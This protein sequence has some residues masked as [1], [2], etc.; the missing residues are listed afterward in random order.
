[1]SPVYICVLLPFLCFRLNLLGFFYFFELDIFIILL[2]H[3]WGHSS[4]Q[5]IHLYSCT[6]KATIVSCYPSVILQ[7]TSR[8]D[9]FPGTSTCPNFQTQPGFRW[10]MSHNPTKSVI[11]N[12]IIFH[13]IFFKIEINTGTRAKM[14]DCML[15]RIASPTYWETRPWRRL[16]HSKQIFRRMALGINRGR[17]QIL[18]WKG[19][20]LGTLHKIAEC[21]DV[22]CALGSS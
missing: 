7:V 22:L 18:P 5:N 8:P 14:A 17:P 11:K 13:E 10:D 3:T 9:L 4:C 12:K 16:A 1:M 2:V 15:L 6:S 21:Q 19:R 20:R